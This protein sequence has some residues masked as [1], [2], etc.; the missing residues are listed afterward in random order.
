MAVGDYKKGDRV[1]VNSR[2]NAQQGKQ[3]TVR[4][5]SAGQH[6]IMFDGD[7]VQGQIGFFSWWLDPLPAGS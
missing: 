6:W 7:E 4:Y 2:A 3:G 5:V 1:V